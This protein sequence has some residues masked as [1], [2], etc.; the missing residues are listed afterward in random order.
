MKTNV[1]TVY[2]KPFAEGFNS[3]A[4]SPSRGNSQKAIVF[5][6]NAVSRVFLQS[7]RIRRRNCLYHQ[8]Y[9]ILNN[10][11]QFHLIVD[12]EPDKQR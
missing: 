10:N 11:K 9:H 8:P 2:L 5:G 6:N 12:G 7:N 3:I 4:Q 1:P